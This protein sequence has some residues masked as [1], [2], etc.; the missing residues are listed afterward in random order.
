[1]N[2][3]SKKIKIKLC[4]FKLTN[5][6]I[7]DRSIKLHKGKLDKIEKF[8]ERKLKFYSP[9]NFK[10][11]FKE[12]YDSCHIWGSGSTSDITK[13]FI[14][15]REDF[16]HIGFGFSCLLNINFDFYFIENASHKNV[17]LLTAQN[18]ALEK[19]I[20]KKK[21]ILVFKNLWQREK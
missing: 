5:K 1:M 17:N 11:L 8:Y 18:K 9:L 15:D 16:F 20:S 4:N 19:F 3:I 10:Y 21:T 6:L 2:K 14:K 12:K 13:K 7:T